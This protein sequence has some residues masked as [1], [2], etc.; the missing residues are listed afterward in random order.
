[1]MY[2]EIIYYVQTED[3]AKQFGIVKQSPII[4]NTE[5]YKKIQAGNFLLSIVDT[6]DKNKIMEMVRDMVFAI[7]KEGDTSNKVINGMSKIIEK[8]LNDGVVFV[9]SAEQALYIA[10]ILARFVDEDYEIM[11]DVKQQM[12]DREAMKPENGIDPSIH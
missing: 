3:G 2:E 6:V 8:I 11:R 7:L 1:M 4:I 9:I 5:E 12:M 10:N